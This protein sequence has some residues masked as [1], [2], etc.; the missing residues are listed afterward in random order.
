VEA[1]HNSSLSL[2]P[3]RRHAFVVMAGSSAS[4][5]D[6]ICLSSN[7]RAVGT[8]RDLYLSEVAVRTRM[9]EAKPV[10]RLYANTISSAEGTSRQTPARRGP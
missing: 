8:I 5:S 3:V 2:A 7:D 1:P 6:K 4:Y 9:R 10:L